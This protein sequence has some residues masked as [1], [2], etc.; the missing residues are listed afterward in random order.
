MP[1]A[2][3]ITGRE[4]PPAVQEIDVGDPGPGQVRVAVQAATVN[5][6]DAFVASGYVWDSMPHEFPVVLGRDFAGLVDAVG[7]DVTAVH[8]GD[9]ITG[10]V[11]ALDLY[12][13]VMAEQIL[14]EADRV[15][16]VP[17]GVTPQQA[18]AAGGL[19]GLGGLDVVDALAL[20]SDDVVLI[21]GATGGVGVFA[22]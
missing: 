1:R 3:V 11:T 19:A 14:F 12:V 6:I 18:A 22:V 5:G 17:D 13:G 21:S 2:L 7:D 15:V 4:E 9:T 8:T 10:V 20:T 16:K